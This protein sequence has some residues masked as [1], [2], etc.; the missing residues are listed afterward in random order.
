MIHLPS[1]A[2]KRIAVCLGLSLAIGCGLSD[3]EK[4]IDQQVARLKV[5]DE[6]NMYLGDPIEQKE[7]WPFTVCLRLP[8]VLVP[9][10]KID[11]LINSD[12]KVYYF[13]EDSKTRLNAWIAASLI[14]QKAKEKDKDKG[15]EKGKYKEMS[16]K[17][18]R[19]AVQGALGDAWAGQ[20]PPRPLNF[21]TAK[22]ETITG[23]VRETIDGKTITTPDF[24]VVI[25]P[26]LAEHQYALQFQFC[27]HVKVQHQ[28][29]IVFQVP[30]DMAHKKEVTT[31]I[32]LSL[33]SLDIGP[34]AD[35]R[36]SMYLK[37]RR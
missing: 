37:Y 15:K 33:K 13:G 8:K 35:R 30:K 27:Y 34:D 32:D 36:R 19:N 21:L 10:P 25:V 3:Y 9:N 24:E 31:A 22:N 14:G 1:G 17:E 16:L 18:F 4:R 11:P 6:D 23:K 5:F 29:A 20:K 12:L 7:D 2:A 28:I 26:E